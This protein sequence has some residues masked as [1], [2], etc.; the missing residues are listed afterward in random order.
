MNCRLQIADCGLVAR[1]LAPSNP[2][3]LPVY[4]ANQHL[5]IEPT[6]QP[7]PAVRSRQ[8]AV[9]NVVWLLLF[10]HVVTSVAYAVA[11]PI[12]EAPDE[13]SHISYVEILLRTGQ[14]PTIP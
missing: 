7:K 2:E 5:S 8:S 12:G 3:A 9:R 1:S 6:E 13:P 11:V 14:L 4:E 10:V